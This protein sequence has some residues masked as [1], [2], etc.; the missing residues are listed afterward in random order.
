MLNRLRSGS[1]ADL[2]KNCLAPKAIGAVYAHLDELVA[3][4]AAVDFRE[5]RGREPGSADP[6]DGIERVRLCLQFAPLGG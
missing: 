1:P 3:F 6:H 4:Q 5:D 2:L